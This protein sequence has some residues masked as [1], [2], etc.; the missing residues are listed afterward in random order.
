MKR[1][2]PRPI[3]GTTWEAAE[4]CD[5]PDPAPVA[6]GAPRIDNKACL[7]IPSLVSMIEKHCESI[8]IRRAEKPQGRGKK[9]P[10]K[11]E[12]SS[13]CVA[14]R[15]L[16]CS[17]ALGWCGSRYASRGCG[18]RQATKKKNARGPAAVGRRRGGVGIDHLAGACAARA[19][20]GADATTMARM[21]RLVASHGRRVLGPPR[22]RRVQYGR[23][24]GCAFWPMSAPSSQGCLPGWGHDGRR[25]GFWVE[26]GG[27]P[28]PRVAH[29]WVIDPR[30]G[31]VGRTR[32]IEQAWS[33]GALWL[34]LPLVAP[35]F[36]Q[37][38]DGEGS[39]EA[40]GHLTLSPRTT[41]TQHSS[42]Q[43]PR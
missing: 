11:M 28:L 22:C 26:K 39:T 17:F 4:R 42:T 41:C 38:Q 14:G 33:W 23:I 37:G 18:R 9:I 35:S 36:G 10:F 31:R 15:S 21:T 25:V 3:G 29:T 32:E 27:H 7:V 40:T 16:P 2:L 19:C 34:L 13:R 20:W 1:C 30:R 8:S 24:V 5:R 6:T 12:R 43:E